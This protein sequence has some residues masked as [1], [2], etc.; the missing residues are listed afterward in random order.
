MNY[1]FFINLSCDISQKI[2][3]FQ[4]L[5]QIENLFATRTAQISLHVSEE[6]TNIFKW[7]LVLKLCYKA[8][9]RIQFYSFCFSLFPFHR[10]QFIFVLFFEFLMHENN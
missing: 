8:I 2:V 6:E 10:Y 5:Y 3:N 4:G 1:V 7:Q 9:E